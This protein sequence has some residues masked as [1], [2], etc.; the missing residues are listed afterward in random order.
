MRRHCSTT[1][2]PSPLLPAMNSASRCRPIGERRNPLSGG[3]RKEGEEGERGEE[4]EEGSSAGVRDP[5]QLVVGNLRSPLI[6]CLISCFS[7]VGCLDPFLSRRLDGRFHVFRSR[8][9]G[10]LLLEKVG[11]C[12]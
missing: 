2:V 6:R 11:L 10:S 7:K 3:R 4:K 8:I 12:P 9:W 5:Q 1:L